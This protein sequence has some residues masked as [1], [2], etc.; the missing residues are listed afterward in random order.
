MGLYL[1]QAVDQQKLQV[2]HGEPVVY[3]APGSSEFT[4]QR[5]D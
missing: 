3:S 5:P 4:C 2:L 1:Q